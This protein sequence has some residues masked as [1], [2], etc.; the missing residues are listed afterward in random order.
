MLCSDKACS[1]PVRFYSECGLVSARGRQLDLFREFSV[2]V[3][4][5]P[6]E[7]GEVVGRVAAGQRALGGDMALTAGCESAR[8]NWRLSSA[9]ISRGAPAGA[10]MP[11][12]PV[13]S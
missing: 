4:F 9:T 11:V 1:L 8:T 12:Q 5:A 2:L 3:E 6:D 7:A 10:S 13:I